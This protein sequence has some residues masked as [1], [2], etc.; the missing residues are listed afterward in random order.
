M[1]FEVS[2]QKFSEFEL[3]YTELPRYLDFEYN[4]QRQCSSTWST[5]NQACARGLI[6]SNCDRI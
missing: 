1:L 5:P 3:E 2:L 4:T 6:F